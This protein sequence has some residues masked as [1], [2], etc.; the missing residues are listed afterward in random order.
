MGE[1]ETITRVS[2]RVPSTV[3]ACFKIISEYPREGQISPPRQTAALPPLSFPSGAG[4]VSRYGP[5]VSE[6]AAFSPLPLAPR[7]SLQ[8]ALPT[9][10]SSPVTLLFL[11]LRVAKIQDRDSRK[12]LSSSHPGC[13]R[14]SWPPVT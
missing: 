7:L 11:S 14:N 3:S 9:P 2:F 13:G 4:E 6:R 12:S 1:I 5:T 10:G 8:A